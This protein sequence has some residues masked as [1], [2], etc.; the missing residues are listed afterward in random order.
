[1]FNSINIGIDGVEF[2]YIEGG[3]LYCVNVGIPDGVSYS[4][5]SGMWESAKEVFDS[6]KDLWTLVDERVDV[7]ELGGLEDRVN[8]LENEVSGLESE[9]SQLESAL[10]DAETDIDDLT[11]ANRELEEEIKKLESEIEDIH[12]Q[13]D[14]DA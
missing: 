8:E 2:E 14:E 6:G 1:M 13:R 11:R 10:D 12:R 9:I 3:R 7:S 5:W 4:Q